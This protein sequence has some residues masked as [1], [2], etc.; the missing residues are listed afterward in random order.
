MGIQADGKLLIG[1]T[2]GYSAGDAGGWGLVRL[3][4][5]GSVDSGFVCNLANYYSGIYCLAVQ[6]DG[7]IVVG[8]DFYRYGNYGQQTKGRIARLNP[9]G[10]PDDQFAIGAGFDTG[11]VL[12]LAIQP[13][14][15]ILAGGYFTAFDGVTCRSVARLNTDGTLDTTFDPGMGCDG[16]VSSLIVQTDGKV[17]VG[18]R[19]TTFG[20]ASHSAVAR[21][22]PN[23]AL[24]TGFTATGLL[25]SLNAYDFLPRIQL[26]DDGALL[27]AQ[28]SAGLDFVNPSGLVRLT[29]DPTQT[30]ADWLAQDPVPGD[31]SGLLDSAADDGVANVLKYALGVPPLGDAAAYLPT[32]QITEPLTGQAQLSLVFAR[33]FG[34]DSVRY[35]LEISSDLANWQEVPGDIEVLG[36]AVNGVQ[37][38]RLGE[39]GAGKEPRRF[40]RLKVRSSAP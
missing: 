16:A 13:D 9:D 18:G 10:T 38:V 14:G 26:A 1:G 27:V 39:R 25:P 35:A 12:S 32:V 24:D 29:R 2:I 4:T 7:K 31:R 5:D 22:L 6:N 37:F 23:G 34:A 30:Y 21:L 3:N 8:G 17:L 40:A 19:F 11:A 20:G 28:M 33:N 15:K 36:P